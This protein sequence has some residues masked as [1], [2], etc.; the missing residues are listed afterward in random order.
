[1]SKIIFY[2]LGMLISQLVLMPILLI[3]MRIADKRSHI[4]GGNSNPVS[5][6]AILVLLALVWPIGIP[7]A[8]I[9][10]V[11]YAMLS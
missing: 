9:A 1:M 4:N 5:L 3:M 8:F 6:L 7:V 2:I 10:M 11:I